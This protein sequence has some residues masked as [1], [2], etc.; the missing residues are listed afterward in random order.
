VASDLSSSGSPRELRARRPPFVTWIALL[1]GAAVLCY[2]LPPVKI[3]RKH[4]GASASTSPTDIAA[5]AQQAWD[6]RLRTSKAINATELLAAIRTDSDAASK[7]YGRRIG[8][9]GSY[10]YFIAGTGRVLNKTKSRIDL[11]VAEGVKD[12]DV[13]IEAGNIFG[14][15]IR[16][17]TGVFKLIDFENS[18]DFN[19]LSEEL[20]KIVETR[21]LPTLRETAAVGSEV[22]FTGVAEVSDEDLDLRPLRI[23]PIAA[24][25]K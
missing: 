12:S 13:V 17:G 10:Y 8:V 19:Q 14:N 23:V 6:D 24:E 5:A 15:A 7:K 18:K 25:V 3:V 11:A 2:A 20:N 21:V 4:A 16:D 1:L 9:G 22:K